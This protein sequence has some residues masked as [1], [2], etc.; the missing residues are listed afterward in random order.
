VTIQDTRTAELAERFPLGAS[1]RL[2]D[3]ERFDHGAVLAQLRDSE[4]VTWFAEQGVWL[5]TTK[6][7]VDEVHNAP[8]RFVVDVPAN[9]QRV[10][11][12]D[13]MLVVDG[14]QH[15][16]HRAP[17]AAPFKLGAVRSEFTGVI[18]DNVER[19]L[20]GIEG[21][22]E[23]ELAGAFAN[24]FA[25]S[26]ASD[27]L[28]LGF[29]HVDEVHDI[30]NDF[31][32]GLVGYEDPVAL[33]RARDAG[34]RLQR[35][36]ME[37]VDRLRDAPDGS[38]LSAVLHVD[39][40]ARLP[41]E[42][43]FAN[44]RVILFGAIETVESMILNTTWALLHHPDQHRALLEDPGLWPAAVQEGLRFIPPVGYSDRWAAYDT[45]LGGVPIA[46]GD[47]LLPVFHAANRDPAAFADPE[48]FDIHRRGDDRTNLSF[49]KGIHMCLGV[50]LA[51]LQGQMA[52]RGLFERLPGLRL[53]PQRPC[54]P[55]GFNFRRPEHLHVR[56]QI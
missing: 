44:L 35:F 48:R 15:D 18:A 12:G 2:A 17:F 14:A 9:P 27:I 40:D 21:E 36:L 41:D 7:L 55:E 31:A 39:A 45:E 49:G 28:G 51:R 24:P 43:L 29:E 4:P 22:G 47:Y 11:L 34:A 46:R 33:T 56:W 42:E 10:V 25:V 32:Q 20:S 30:Y 50:N 26:V 53:N 5:V 37:G 19:L 8:D 54:E 13:M 38:M 3:L 6:A 1:L 52:L 23:A 16:R